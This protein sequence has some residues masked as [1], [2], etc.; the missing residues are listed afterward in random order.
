MFLSRSLPKQ[1]DKFKLVLL[2]DA[3][4]GKTSLVSVMSNGVFSNRYKS[5]IGINVSTITFQTSSND[6]I[7]FECYDI[8]GREQFRVNIND[9]Y[10]I[11][12]CMILM[13]DFT[14]RESYENLDS[15]YRDFNFNKMS[16][17]YCYE[18]EVPWV[19]VGNK[20][21]NHKDAKVKQ[22]EVN[23]HKRFYCKYYTISCKTRYHVELPF[24]CIAKMLRKDPNL[25][26]V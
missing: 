2:G 15:W 25:K 6:P 13:F 5:T 4:V 16:W 20:V 11:F 9:F 1:K 3:A 21:E 12:D 14:N 19:L 17:R 8:P 23:F 7:T 10:K 26:F 24:L 18:G 22:K